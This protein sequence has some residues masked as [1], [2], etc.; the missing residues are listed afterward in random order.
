MEITYF[1]EERVFQIQTPNTTYLCGIAGKDW[2]GH[3]YYGKRMEDHRAGYL[4]RTE[5]APFTPEVNLREKASFLE[6][7][8][9]EYSTW[10]IGDFREDCLK[11]RTEQG[12]SACELHYVSHWIF[13]GKPELPGLPAT[14]EGSVEKHMQPGADTSA[15]PESCRENG[16]CQTLEILCR[17]EILKLDVILS[18]SVF[19]DTDAIARSVRIENHSQEAL[20]L[21]RVYSVCLDMEDKE[22]EM[23]TLAGAWARERHME[24]RP[25]AHGRQGVASGRGESS[26]QEHPFLALLGKHTTQEAGEVYG[27]HFVYSG[28]FTAQAEKTQYDHVRM[29][30]GINPEGFCWKLAPEETFQTPEVILVYSDCGLDGMTHEFHRLYRNHLIRSPWLHQKR[31]VLLNNWEATYFNFDAEKIFEIAR[32]AKRL[33]IEMLVLDDG[34]F[35]ERDTD[36]CSLGDWQVNEK[37]L[38][39]GLTALADRITG[40]GMKFGLWFEPEMVSP[41]SRLYEAHPDWAIQIPGRPATQ[42]R[43]QYVLDLSRQEIVD[44]VYE[45]VASVLRSA[46]ISYVKWDMNRH[47]TDLSS[48]G[49]SGERQGELSHRYMLGV[50][51]LQERLLQEFPKLLLENCS[52]GGARFD[53]GMLYYSPQIWCSDDTDAMERLA[54]QEGT[55]LLYP[56]SCIGAH[57]SDCP[58]H[59]TGRVVPF[60]TR[61]HVALAGTFGYELD[62]TRISE[63]EQNQIPGQV[64]LYH[65]YNDLVREGDYYRIASAGDNHLYDCWQVTSQDRRRSLVTY[66]Q[67][68]A[69]PNYHSRTIMLKGLDK[70]AVYELE[71]TGKRYSGELLMHAGLLVPEM[72]GDYVSV[73]YS[74]VQV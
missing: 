65:K 26:H 36:D 25:L 51:Q 3:I 1:E 30:M 39:G 33:G 50:Y 19:D 20:Y 58:N 42:G 9:M 37:K 31:P 32:E 11:V 43:A 49:L 4:M 22:Y 35:G 10:G 29:T 8:P 14:F 28:N 6:L 55:A 59:V 66:I 60:E 44:Y 21:D 12:Y 17:D 7:F 41:K 54:I 18:Y 24:R 61:G 15:S 45:A 67:V 63:E 46:E 70:D 69:R 72:K 40:L 52:S 74:L 68:Q 73:L 48:Y 47:L 5:E 38:P 71:G 27:M 64:E 57:V 62:V 34:W 16:K 23:L 53:P 13:D 56:L 2:L